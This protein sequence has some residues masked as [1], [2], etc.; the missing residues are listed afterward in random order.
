MR[1]SANFF[2]MLGVKPALGRDFTSAEDTPDGWHVVMLSDGLWRRR[3]GADPA[4]IGRVIT[5]NDRPYTIVGVMPASFEPLIS[6]R[7][8]Q[9]A[10]MWALVGYDRSQPSACRDCQHLKAI[11]RIKDGTSLETAR[12]DID[13]VQSELRKAYPAVYP[14]EAMTL[15]PLRDELMGGLRP[16]LMVLM[17]AVACVLLIAC[18]NVANLLLARMASRERDLA[19]RAA[20]GAGRARLVR[21]LM[22]ESAL[23]ALAGGVLGVAV[24]AIA[25]PL[26]TRMA[27]AEMS[28]AHRR[29][30]G[31]PCA[32]LLDAAVACDRLRL[33]SAAG[34]P[35]DRSIDPQA[36]LQGDGRKTSSRAD[37]A[38]AASARRGRCR[39][40]RSSCSS[41]AGLMIKSVGRLLGVNPGSIPIVCL[42]MQISM[43]GQAYA[44]DEAVV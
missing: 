33:R 17:G 9:R 6:E 2:H 5:M 4:A 44:K 29:A 21:Q 36:A 31:R 32:R 13:A 41:G 1:V 23:L 42:S 30:A 35:R 7:F 14:P 28:R 18:A 27:P 16:A 8:Y 25:V 12:A 26:L 43:V 22:V 3:F 39:A 10:E 11:G 34:D 37:F 24:S 19:L 38:R 15:V 20:L 40:S